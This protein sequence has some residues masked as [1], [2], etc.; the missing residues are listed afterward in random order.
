MVCSVDSCLNFIANIYVADFTTDSQKSTVNEKA[1]SILTLLRA[2]SLAYVTRQSLPNIQPEE[3]I[4]IIQ[5]SLGY[6]YD[7]SLIFK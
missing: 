6:C 1:Q 3:V 2:H 4:R 5:V 7:T